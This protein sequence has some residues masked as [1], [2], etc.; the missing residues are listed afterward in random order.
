MI[1]RL[2]CDDRADGGADQRRRPN[3]SSAC[4]SPRDLAVELQRPPRPASH[5]GRSRAVTTSA[6]AA[7]T[8][9][10]I[11]AAARSSP[12]ERIAAR[13]GEERGA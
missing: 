10:T 3:A 5:G 2:L 11:A 13:L 4:Q 9:P 1:A 12:R 8:I 7:S 6:S